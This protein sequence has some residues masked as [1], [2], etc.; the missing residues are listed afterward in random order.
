MK[1]Q[2]TYNDLLVGILSDDK[3]DG[4]I[5]FEYSPAF[6]S[7]QIQL[8]PF[9]LPLKTGVFH[10]TSEAFCHLFGLFY[11]SLP[12]RWGQQVLQARLAKEGA[13]IENLS[14]LEKLCYVGNRGI[15]A[16]AYR[17]DR[18]HLQAEESER[19][20]LLA[21]A[22][23]ATNIVEGSSEGVL[24]ELASSGGTAG[25][26][27]PKILIGVKSSDPDY[28]I[29]RAFAIPSGY[30]PWLLKIETAPERQY[31]RVEYAYSLM[32]TSAGIEMPPTR[33][34]TQTSP[35]GEVGHFAVKRFDI[36]DGI[37]VH[38]HSLAGLLHHDFNKPTLDY[39]TYL[40]ACEILTKSR[41]YL[42]EIFRRIAF[43][44]RTGI[45]D[46]HP[47]N[48]AFLMDASG[49]WRPSPAYDIVLSRGRPAFPQPAHEMPVAGRNRAVGKDWLFAVG[50][51]VGLQKNQI[52]SIL[53]AIEHSVG[54]W[55]EFAEKAGI[56][57]ERSQEVYRQFEPWE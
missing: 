50:S 8:S 27:R 26:A 46:D 3:A 33:L 10:H 42:P 43:N 29:A 1:V 2:V 54:N 9:N 18:A 52:K 16:L 12:D 56:K 23:N 5:Y 51:N 14:T 39:N 19:L 53:D 40:R 57:T 37:R 38:M 47:K 4:N 11:D 32:A 34:I 44:Y 36:I 49:H 15:G 24:D 55:T 35:K 13:S 17:P 22:R 20:D 6:L 21:V 7:T 45:R 30:E 31:G 41:E 48:H 25:G 28:L